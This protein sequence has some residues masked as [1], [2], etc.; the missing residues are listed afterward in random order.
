MAF[1]LS[2]AFDTVAAKQLAPT[3]QALGVTGRELRWFLCYMTGGK[4]RVVWDS[5][6]SGLI[7]V[8]Y[9]PILFIILTSGMAD[10]LG[11]KEDENIV[12]TDDSNV[13]QT[14]TTKEEV[15]GELA[16]KAAFFVEYTRRMSLSM[17]AAKTQLLFSSPAG[18]VSETTVEVEVSLIHRG[19]VIELLGVRY[20]RKLSTTP[21]VK[22]LFAVVRQRDS[23][24][25]RLSNHLPRGAY[26]RQLSYGLVIGKFSHS[27]AAVARPRLE[28]EDSASVIWS[29]IQ[30]AFNDVAWSITGERRRNH[31]TIEDLLDLAGFKSANR[32]VVK[33]I[34]AESWSCFHSDD[35]NCGAWNHVGR[36]VFSDKRTATAKTTQKI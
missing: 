32:M 1:D 11:V 13:W 16:E 34:A 14:G 9:G 25:A 33:A 36:I 15:A 18:N 19:D 5:T 12:Y 10:F 6:V 21:H 4:Q 8:L 23:V 24:V 27:L 31:V 28:Q 35:G 7:D 17:N 26:L 29:G 30:V 2:A 20:D 22:S 3:L